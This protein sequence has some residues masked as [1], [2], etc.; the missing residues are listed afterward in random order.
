L[1]PVT[2]FYLNFLNDADVLLIN[3]LLDV[4]FVDGMVILSTIGLCCFRLF[5]LNL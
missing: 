1:L 3:S 2:C 4:F 5:C